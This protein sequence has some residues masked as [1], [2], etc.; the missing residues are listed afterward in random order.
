MIKLNENFLKLKD[1]YLFSD[2]NKKVKEYTKEN[3]DAN[4]IKLGI[5]DVT[6]PIP[7]VIVDA[8]K[9]SADEMGNINTFKGYGPEQGYDFLKEKIIEN[10]YKNIDIKMDEIF[11]SDGAKCDTGNIIEI[12]NKNIRVGITDPVYPVY[13]DTN[14]MYTYIY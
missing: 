8:I 7:S 10:E 14:V 11:I 13:L 3:P 12:F 9:K 5:G 6:K 4:I 1:S 2:I